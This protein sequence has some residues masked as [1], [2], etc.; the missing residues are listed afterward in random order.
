MYRL[1]LGE[2]CNAIQIAHT[3]RTGIFNCG[4]RSSVTSLPVR[5]RAHRALDHPA[6]L[7]QCCYNVARHE[8]WHLRRLRHEQ[9]I[10]FVQLGGRRW[11]N[12]STF[13]SG[14]TSSPAASK[15]INRLTLSGCSAATISAIH[16]PIDHPPVPPVSAPAR[17]ES[18]RHGR[19]ARYKEWRLVAAQVSD[20]KARLG[21][22]R[23]I[24][25]ASALEPSPCTNTTT[26]PPTSPLPGSARDDQPARCGFRSQ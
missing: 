4:S 20:A 26:G 17:H 15:S 14:L 3:I 1:R 25:P 23:A 24:T 19:W 16:P 11:H 8:S 10:Q 9:R 13:Q 7:P 12:R 6:V 2:R 5:I 18:H 21:K 22:I